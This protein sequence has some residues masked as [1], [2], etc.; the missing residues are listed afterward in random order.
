MCI[1]RTDRLLILHS[2]RE[3]GM[4]PHMD[5]TYETEIDDAVF[6][7]RERVEATYND[8]GLYRF[9]LKVGQ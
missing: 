3:K 7:R 5:L 9:T 6:V 4:F 2:L 8:A 1:Y